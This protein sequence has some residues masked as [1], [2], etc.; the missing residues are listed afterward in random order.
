MEPD[1]EPDVYVETRREDL[2]S[3]FDKDVW[4]A[5]L[6]INSNIPLWRRVGA[7]TS[8][9]VLITPI[10]LFAIISAP[11]ALLWTWIRAKY[12]MATRPWAKVNLKK[13]LKSA[14]IDD[15]KKLREVVKKYN[16]VTLSHEKCICF[17]TKMDMFKFM[18]AYP[19]CVTEISQEKK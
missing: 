13:F 3:L 14:D 7:R 11:V 16:A 4:F 17:K 6:G 19:D 15:N 18:M 8:Y 5:D 12:Y 9:I 10:F 1:D 2:K